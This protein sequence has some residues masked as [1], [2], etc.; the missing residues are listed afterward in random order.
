MLVSSLLRDHPFREILG[1]EQ[2]PATGI[3]NPI[4]ELKPPPEDRLDKV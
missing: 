4:P 2:S 1:E 3:S